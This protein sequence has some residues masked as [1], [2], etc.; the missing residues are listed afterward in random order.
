MALGKRPEL[1]RPTKTRIM[2][3]VN[4]TDWLGRMDR[5]ADA[6][7]IDEEAACT[8]QAIIDDEM[9]GRRSRS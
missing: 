4:A 2:A 1:D 3:G 6:V 7:D 9:R 8:V 5:A